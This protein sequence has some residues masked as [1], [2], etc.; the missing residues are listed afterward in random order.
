MRDVKLFYNEGFDIDVEANGNP[1]YLDLDTQT[2]DQRAAVATA[3]CATSIPG[4]ESVGIDWG[5]LY[6]EDESQGIMSIYNEAQQMINLC[7]GNEES[8]TGQYMALLDKDELTNKITIR[9]IKGGTS[10]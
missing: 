5:H 1:I 10:Q 6:E 8:P 4:F 2:Q 9:T 7:A 3:I